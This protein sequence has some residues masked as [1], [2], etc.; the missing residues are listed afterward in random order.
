MAR[1]TIGPCEVDCSLYMRSWNYNLE[2]IN[3]CSDR[4]QLSD[5]HLLP[6]WLRWRRIVVVLYA[7]ERLVIAFSVFVYCWSK[8]IA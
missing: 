6:G 5:A 3:I 2:L 7:Q 1:H 8:R 4:A